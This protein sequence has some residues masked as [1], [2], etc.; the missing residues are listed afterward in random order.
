MTY[1]YVRVSTARQDPQ[2][3]V[4]NIL[5]FDSTAQIFAESYTGRT[6]DRPQFQKLVKKLKSGDTLICDSVSRF[7][8]DAAEGAALYVELFNRGVELRF[9]NEPVCD[10]ANYREALAAADLPAM[11]TTG[12][13]ATDELMSAIHDALTRYM[14]RIAA[15]TFE[16]AFAQ[17]EKEAADLSTRTKGGIETARANGKQIGQRQGAKFNVRKAAA[18]KAVILQHSRDFGGTLADGECMKLAGVSRNSF[19]KYKSELKGQG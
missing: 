8:R 5:A 19:Y 1:G 6:T 16:T 2:R 18:A 12:D 7:S 9:L 13:G 15:R 10:S 11:P 14:R 3:Q 4:R 17:A